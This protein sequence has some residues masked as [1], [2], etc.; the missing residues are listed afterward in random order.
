MQRWNVVTAA[1]VAAL[2]VGSAPADAQ[3]VSGST[4]R[5]TGTADVIHTDEHDLFLRFVPSAIRRQGNG[6]GSFTTPAAA[7]SIRDF[8]VVAGPQF[9]NG[10]VTLGGYSFDLYE[11]LPGVYRPDDCLVDPLPG[12]SCTPPRHDVAG[13]PTPFNLVNTASGDPNAPISSRAWFDVRGLVRGPGSSESSSFFGRFEA[14]FPGM[15]YQE[16]LYGAET[17]TL[18]DVRFTGTFT[19]TPEPSTYALMAT[20]L[21]AVAGVARRRR[22]A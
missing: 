15:S 10:L 17:N 4:L 14:S 20:G 3:I 1:V 19:A 5:F 2:A 9:I 13:V 21:A 8:E 22:R 11:M 16:V 18:R 6:T 12:Q 7:G